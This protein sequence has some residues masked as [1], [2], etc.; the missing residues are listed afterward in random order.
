M[1]WTVATALVLII[2]CAAYLHGEAMKAWPQS[3]TITDVV[4]LLI[5]FELVGLKNKIKG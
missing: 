1:A 3:L 5:Y 4:V 2:V